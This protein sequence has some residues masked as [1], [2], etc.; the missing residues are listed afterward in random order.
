MRTPVWI[1]PRRRKIRVPKRSVAGEDWIRLVT[2]IG[3]KRD[4]ASIFK[5]NV[6]DKLFVYSKSGPINK[7]R[8]HE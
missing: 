1:I 5:D 3:K 2:A 8:I 6:A 7:K 4:A